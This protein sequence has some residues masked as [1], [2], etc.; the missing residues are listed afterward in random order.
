MS[1]VI[2]FLDIV[3]VRGVDN[4]ILIRDDGRII[5]HN[6]K[7]PEPVSKL[8]VDTGHYCLDI[9]E[10]GL[11]KFNHII[12]NSRNGERLIVFPMGKFFAGIVSNS[13]VDGSETIAGVFTFLKKI[14]ATLKN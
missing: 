5:S 4:Y 14:V 3:K 7:N 12:M 6:V 2:S 11:G 8:V 10:K 1:F 13:K 9:Q